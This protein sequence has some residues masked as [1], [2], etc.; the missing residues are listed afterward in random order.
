MSA[1]LIKMCLC[2]CEGREETAPV[3]DC[4]SINNNNNDNK[5]NMARQE[6]GN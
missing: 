4:E 2:L 5:T 6:K 1:V 3:N